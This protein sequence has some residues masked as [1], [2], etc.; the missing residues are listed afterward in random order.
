M[1]LALYPPCP[2]STLF[3]FLQPEWPVKKGEEHVL[4]GPNQGANV[5]VLLT[6][7][8]LPIYAGIIIYAP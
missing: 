2:K 8:Y 4:S 3:P 1:A 6:S 5:I 7:D